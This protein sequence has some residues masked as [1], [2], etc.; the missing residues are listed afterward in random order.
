MKTWRQREALRR[1]ALAPRKSKPMPAFLAS[2]FQL[3]R[4]AYHGAKKAASRAAS[5]ALPEEKRVADEVKRADEDV[6]AAA[7]G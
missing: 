4:S 1:L 5:R 2:L 3:L 6:A 7:E